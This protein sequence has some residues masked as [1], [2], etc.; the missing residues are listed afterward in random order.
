MAKQLGDRI[1]ELRSEHPIYKSLRQFAEKLGKSPSWVSKVERNLE[2]PGAE[3]LTLIARLLDAKADELFQLAAQIEPEVEEGITNRYAEVSGLLRTLPFLSV[4]QIRTL[5][6]EANR[7]KSKNP[8]LERRDDDSILMANSPAFLASRLDVPWTHD[9]DIEAAAYALCGAFIAA[10]FSD[11]VKV[12]HPP[13]CPETLIYDFLDARDRLTLLTEDSLGTDE[14]G[15]PIAGKMQIADDAS[16][17]GCIHIDCAVAATPLYPFTVAHEI[18]HWVLH[19][20][21]VLR[22]REQMSL[23]DERPV[24]TQTLHRHLEGGKAK[25][26][27]EEWQANRFAVHLLLPAD[28]VKAEFLSRYEAPLDYRDRC[29]KD[30]GFRHLY[31]ERRLYARDVARQPFFKKSGGN[32]IGEM[33]KPLHELFAVSCQAMAIRLEEL[34]L[35]TDSQQPSRL[36]NA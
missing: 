24:Q 33:S 17:G 1:R 21:H 9:R 3:T 12:S 28:L 36:F 26:P 8:D 10:Q 11:G 14:N 19:R 7:L 5:E 31:T 13:V 4:E 23:F 16:E 25:L 32:T 34:Q 22:A 27:P 35:I 29:E 2:K 20:Q 30:A 15:F 6:T 18:G